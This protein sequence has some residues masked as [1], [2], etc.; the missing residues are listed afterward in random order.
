MGS[1]VILIYSS[2][3][4]QGIKSA[5]FAVEQYMAR[6]LLIYPEDI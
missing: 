6:G 3:E 2:K 4:S 5:R 1:N